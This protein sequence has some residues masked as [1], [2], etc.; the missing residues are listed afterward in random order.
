MRKAAELAAKFENLRGG[1]KMSKKMTS[2]LWFDQEK[3]R[4]ATELYAATC[5]D[6]HV[7]KASALPTETPSVREGRN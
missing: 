1:N 2:C 5:L 7:G 4:E 6:S 3:A